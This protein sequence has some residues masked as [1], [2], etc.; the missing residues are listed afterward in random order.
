[1]LFWVSAIHLA[2]NLCLMNLQM[3]FVHLSNWLSGFQTAI[4]TIVSWLVRPC[5]CIPGSKTAKYYKN[6]L[7][8]SFKNH[9][10]LYVTFWVCIYSNFA[11]MT[12]MAFRSPSFE[13][14]SKKHSSHPINFTTSTKIY[15]HFEPFGRRTFY[16]GKTFNTGPTFFF[17]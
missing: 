15:H 12:N 13:I 11:R 17:G 8:V 9:S 16:W 4:N 2:F 1:M 6:A 5:L 3:Y 7:A 10:N 14:T